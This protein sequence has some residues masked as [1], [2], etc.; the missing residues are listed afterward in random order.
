M[1]NEL[2]CAPTKANCVDDRDCDKGMYCKAG[3][4]KSVIGPANLTPCNTAPADNVNDC[5]FGMLCVDFGNGPRCQQWAT[6]ANG[7]KLPTIYT[8]NADG[9]LLCNETTLSEDKTCMPAPVSTGPT[10]PQAT[11]V[12]CEY[13]TFTDPAN[14]TTPTKN[15]IAAMCGFNQDSNFYC[16]KFGGD[17]N[18]IWW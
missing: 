12:Q 16:P 17:F 1:K 9:V 10:G 7:Q 13:N 11:A 4:C 8:K 18:N 3:T 14:P 5:G 15:T 6:L 2:F